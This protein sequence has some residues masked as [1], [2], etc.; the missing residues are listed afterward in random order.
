[1]I[2]VTSSLTDTDLEKK[3]YMRALSFVSP[4]NQPYALLD[5]KLLHFRNLSGNAFNFTD[6]QGLGKKNFSIVYFKRP[7]TN[8]N[9]NFI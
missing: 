7:I 4:V 9:Y 3:T 6:L 5:L 8:Y 2:N 1:M